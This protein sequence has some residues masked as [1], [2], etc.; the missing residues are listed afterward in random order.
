LSTATDQPTPARHIDKSIR[1]GLLV[2]GRKRRG[3][4]MPWGQQIETW[5]SCAADRLPLQAIQPETRVVDDATLRR[6]IQELRDRSCDVLVVMQP[7]MGD[8][9]LVPILAQWWGGSP[10]VLWATPERPDSPTVSSCSLVGTHVFAS[11]LRQMQRPFELVYGHPNE[12]Q[13]LQQLTTAIR[14][15][16][17]TA[18]IRHAKAGLVGNP[19]PGFLSMHPDPALMS[20][21]LGAQ[22][23]HFGLQE[24]YDLIES[25]SDEAVAAD[26]EVVKGLGLPLGEDVSE[27]DFA[28]NSRYYL[29]IGQLIADESLDAVAVRCWPELPNRYG[30]WPYLA[31]A[32]LASRNEAVALEGDVDGALSCLMGRLLNLGVGYLSDWL[33][34]D[35]SSITLWHPGHAPLEFCEPGTLRLGRHFNTGHPLVVDATLAPDRPITLVR[36]WRCDDA[37]RLMACEAHTAPPRRPLTGAH[38]LAIVEGRDV[39]QWFDGLCHEGM[40]HHLTVFQGQHVDLW[41]RLARLLGVQWIEV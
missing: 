17:A 24:F 18:R 10:L 32:R 26:V 21:Q 39:R 15:C 2:I 30:Q 12:E 3:F 36:L 11:I 35:E 1:A 22:L 31:M 29:A 13:T 28:G 37:Y 7:I 4:D 19:A 25:Q 5:A 33:E 6:A 9:R 23:H 34:H 8:G 20:R 27:D 16:T 14:L 40:P 38:G 41:R